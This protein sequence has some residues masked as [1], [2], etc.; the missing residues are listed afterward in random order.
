MVFE[1]VFWIG[2]GLF[3]DTGREISVITVGSPTETGAFFTSCVYVLI[4]VASVQ[5]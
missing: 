1:R 3:E 5:K 2:R 4:L